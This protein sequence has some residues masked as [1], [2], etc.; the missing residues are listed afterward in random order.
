MEVA[1]REL[2]PALVAAAP[3]G[4]ALHRVRQPRRGAGPWD[5]LIPRSRCRCASPTALEWVRGEQQLLPRLAARAGV[6]LRPLAR[7]DR[8][9][10]GA[11]PARRDGA[12]PD[13]PRAS[14][15]RTPGIRALGMRVL[16]PLA[17]RRSDRVIVDSQ[18]DQ[19]RPRRAARD[20][21]AERIDVVPLGLGSPARAPP[22]AERGVRA[23]L[24]ARRAARA[25][26]RCR[27]S[28]RTRTSRALL[29]AL[30]LLERAP[31]LVLA[32][33]PTAHEHELRARGARARLD[34]DVRWLGWLSRRSS[35]GCGR[36]PR[37]VRVPLALRG[38][39]AA[40]ARGDGARRAGGVLER[41]VAARGGGRRALLFDPHDR[42][43]I[44]DALARCSPAARRERLRA[45]GLERAA[46]SRWERT[47]RAD[48][49]ELRARAARAVGREHRLERALDREPLAR[50]ARTTRACSRAAPRRP[51]TTRDDRRGERPRRRPIG[52]TTPLTPS[53]IELDGGVVGLAHDDAGRAAAAASTTTGRSPRGA[54]AAACSTRARSAA[55][56]R[57]ASTK[58]GRADQP[59]RGRARR[60]PRSTASRSGPSPKMTPRRP[61]TRAA[62]S[63][64]A[65]TTLG[66]RFSGISRPAKTTSGSAVERRS[67]LERARRTRPR[68]R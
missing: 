48:A 8:A 1:A 59:G 26:Q 6:D 44:A 63:A 19:A 62:A 29:D 60:S 52:A 67:A 36:S 43:A 57:A 4:H 13:L 3:P 42:G 50:C 32:G 17:V 28:G 41:L 20:R 7:H 64:T 27:P 12:R 68:A 24:D 39:R 53:S 49:R 14:R 23:R 51:R 21:P 35:R 33:Y 65:A 66:A 58:P 16:V 55:W 45:A 5:E 38:L 9:R 34:D 40:G 46:S 10:V 37:G 54:R 56:T 61:G 31:V 47:A 30:A 2:I 18:S 11:L 15:R 22:L 25:A